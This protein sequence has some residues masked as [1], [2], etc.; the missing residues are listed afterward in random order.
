MVCAHPHY[1]GPLLDGGGPRAEARAILPC[2][3]FLGLAKVGFFPGIISTSR[4]GSRAGPAAADGRDCPGRPGQPVDGR[5][6]QRCSWEDWFDLDGWQWAFSSKE[7]PPSCSAAVPFLLTDRPGQA[8]WLTSAEGQLARPGRWSA[9]GPRRMPPEASTS[10][11]LAEADGQDS[12]P[13][14]LVTNTGGYAMGFWL[15]T[16]LDNMLKSP[17]DTASAPTHALHYLGLVYLARPRCFCFRAIVG[18]H[19]RAEMALLFGQ[20][21]RGCSWR[22]A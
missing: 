9:I 1:L 14:I 8:T 15:P 13:G 18:P 16:F 12:R 7:P 22:S 20:V 6:A 5:S 19:R 2:P 17:A 10:A 3:I 21:R 4:T 11:R